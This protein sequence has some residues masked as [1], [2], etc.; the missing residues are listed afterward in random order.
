MR[1]TIN[2]VEYV[3]CYHTNSVNGDWIFNGCVHYPYKGKWV[4][5]IDVCPKEQ[6]KMT[7]KG[8]I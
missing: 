6:P 4:A 7:N 1:L 2:G 8:E 5:E 3:R